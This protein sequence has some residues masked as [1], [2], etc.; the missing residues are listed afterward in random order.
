[1]SKSNGGLPFGRGSGAVTIIE[2]PVMRSYV[3]KAKIVFFII[4]A[5]VGLLAAT[6][7]VGKWEPKFGA[8]G[9]GIIALITGGLV[10]L[11]PACIIA[12]LVAAWPVL[13]AIW[14]WLPE[15]AVTGGLAAG[16]VE[17]A[18]HTALVP[19]LLLTAVMAGVPAAV[20]PVRR[21]IYRMG[22]CLVSRHRI[23]TCFS[24]FIIT[25]RTGSLPLIL[26]ARPTPAGERM[27]VWL[28]PGLCL[29]DIQ[30]RAEE[31]AAAC[32]ASAVV[33]DLASA[34][35]S[36]L[37]RIDIKRRDPLTGTV[38][39]P[40]AQ[41]L[42]GVIPGRRLAAAPDPVALD[43]PDIDPAEVSGNQ[44][45]TGRLLARATAPPP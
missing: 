19:R 18:G 29:A 41:M 44:D 11:V 42:S 3:R 12:V 21:G 45:R 24:E 35:N 7:L 20:G 9:A 30:D 5:A 13:R 1:M 6:V 26:V 38:A 17:L 22:W 31:I 27:W 37:V 39:S 23:R 16:W 14:W 43:L 2:Q 28:R 40:L 36:A 32:W 34:S 10:G 4:W 25:N 15:L 33:A 8:T